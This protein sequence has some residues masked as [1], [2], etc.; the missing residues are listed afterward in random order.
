MADKCVWCADKEAT[1]KDVEIPWQKTTETVKL[2]GDHC[3]QNTREFYH[4]AETH[5][6]HFLVGLFGL[7]VI[8]LVVTLLM[9]KIDNGGVGMFII[10]AGMGAVII[11]Y[12]FVTPQTIQLFGI[13]NS[14]K[15]VKVMGVLMILG[16]IA[17]AA[18]M[19]FM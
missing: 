1:L 18:I 9:M 2:C 6:V 5:L 15:L 12:P 14:I 8:G 13:K 11:K 10:F 4:Y 17:C 3:E 7:P 16:G 19:P